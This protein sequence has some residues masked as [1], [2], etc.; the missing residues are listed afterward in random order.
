MMKLDLC[1]QIHL[2]DGPIYAV[3]YSPDGSL[4]ASASHDASVLV[5]N[6]QAQ[7]VTLHLQL[8]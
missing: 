3:A 5:F 4:L 6:T 8:L 2:H 7:L 1:K